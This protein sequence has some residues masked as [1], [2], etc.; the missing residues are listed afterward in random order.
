MTKEHKKPRHIYT[1][2]IFMLAI[3]SF[4]IISGSTYNSNLTET[5]SSETTMEAT[6]ETQAAASQQTATEK[7]TKETA[8]EPAETTT[9][10]ISAINVEADL[11]FRIK[12]N[13][14]ENCV[15]I[16]GMDYNGKYSIPYKSFACSVGESNRTPLGTFTIS[17]KYDWRLMIDDSYAQYASRVVGQI[18][19]HSVG[20]YSASHD[21]L[22]YTEY[23]KLG[24]AASLGCIRL[25]CIDAKWIYDNCPS[26]TEVEIY[27]ESN[28]PGPLGKPKS[29]KIPT[30]SKKKHWDPTDPV[31]NNPWH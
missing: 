7:P 31:G 21:D 22:K 24:T 17:D 11:P 9:D 14:V 12:I 4:M 16:Y 20:Y 13:R 10:A 15:T 30:N 26:G 3:S 19:I 1:I 2:I 8:S 29:I 5:S 23:N 25:S 18:L 27:D 28:S 6:S